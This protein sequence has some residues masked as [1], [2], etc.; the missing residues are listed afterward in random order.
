MET[1]L[2][3]LSLTVNSGSQRIQTQ[4]AKHG[5]KQLYTPS[6]LTDPRPFDSQ[7][8]PGKKMKSKLQTEIVFLEPISDKDLYLDCI[9]RTKFYTRQANEKGGQKT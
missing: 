6:H 9:R 4:I 7:K 8:D 5:S 3:E 1:Q 2:Q